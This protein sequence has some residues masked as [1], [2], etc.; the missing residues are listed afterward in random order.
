MNRLLE[1]CLVGIT[2]T[3]SITPSVAAQSLPLQKGVSVEMAAT[4]N[5]VSWPDADEADAL[6]VA[7]THDSRVFLGID[8][9][10]S[11]ALANSLKAELSKKPQKELYIKADARTPYANVEK[12]LDAARAAGAES[13]VLLTAQSGPTK[14]GVLVP[15]F[16][17]EVH[18]G[19]PSRFG[20]TAVAVQ[21]SRSGQQK[22]E[23]KINHEQVPWT[24]LQSSLRHLFRN[25]KEQVVVIKAEDALPFENVVQATDVC[26][27]AGAKVVL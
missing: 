27:S 17:L 25:R 10:T 9:I 12:V 11:A 3:A 24:D 4:R 5:A 8:P 14:P 1:V 13:L 2:L 20:S 19:P 7:I 6:V 23:L 21:L 18:I 22:P 26:R 16:G 15:P